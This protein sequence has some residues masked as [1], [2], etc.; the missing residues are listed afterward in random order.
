MELDRSDEKMDAISWG[1]DKGLKM[2]S[3]KKPFAVMDELIQ[4]ASRD[5]LSGTIPYPLANK[6]IVNGKVMIV[7]WKDG[8]KNRSTCSSADQF[9]VE[10]GFA[11]CLMKKLYGKKRLD[12]MVKKAI[13]IKQKEV[14]DD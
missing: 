2:P 1:W 6:I 13:I 4:K 11:V 8:T 7:L 14:K 5:L 12:R 10:V 3:H 9:D